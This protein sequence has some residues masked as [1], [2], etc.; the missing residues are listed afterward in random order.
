MKIIG[1]LKLNSPISG[2]G[3]KNPLRNGG[4]EKRLRQTRAKN[5]AAMGMREPR[6][7]L[8]LK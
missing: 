4:V 5:F 2:G 3:I 8:R 6:S 1:T 7:P